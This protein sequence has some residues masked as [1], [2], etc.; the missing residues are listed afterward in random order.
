[1]LVAAAAA[2]MLPGVVLQLRTALAAYVGVLQVMVVP[3]MRQAVARVYALATALQ[4]MAAG[5]RCC[6]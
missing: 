6:L 5:W 1:M 2:E 4:H 3:P